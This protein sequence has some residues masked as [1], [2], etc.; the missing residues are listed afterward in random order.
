MT[1]DISKI[2]VGDTVTVSHEVIQ[3]DDDAKF[4]VR[5][6][7]FAWVSLERIVSHHPKPREFKA[8]DKVTYR[9]SHIVYEFV[10]MRHE[11]LCLFEPGVGFRIFMGRAIR[12]L[13]H[14]DEQQ[15]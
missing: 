13:R 1:V 4:P 3:I 5:I 9:D 14:A 7:P 8:G 12:D 15:P 2:N 11:E 6:S 10:A